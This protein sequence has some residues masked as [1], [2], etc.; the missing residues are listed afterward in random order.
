MTWRE[1]LASASFFSL[2]LFFFFF[3][4]GDGYLTILLLNNILYAF[5]QTG[6]L[7]YTMRENYYDQTFMRWMDGLL[8][9][10][11]YGIVDILGTYSFLSQGSGA[12]FSYFSYFPYIVDLATWKTYIF[13]SQGAYI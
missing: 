1:F 2:R 7:S 13:L 4:R 6:H 12:I 8:I 9:I 3:S 10:D 11:R 5:L